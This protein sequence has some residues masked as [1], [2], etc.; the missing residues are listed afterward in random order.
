MFACRSACDSIVYTHRRTQAVRLEGRARV[1]RGSYGQG[2]GRHGPPWSGG[3]VERISPCGCPDGAPGQ[4]GTGPLVTRSCSS[5]WTTGWTGGSCVRSAHQSWVSCI[6]A[7]ASFPP[8]LGSCCPMYGP[9]SERH[10]RPQHPSAS[11]A[12]ASALP[13]A[14][15]RRALGETPPTA[16][17]SRAAGPHSPSCPWEAPSRLSASRSPWWQRGRSEK[18]EEAECPSSQ[19]EPNPEDVSKVSGF[20][21]PKHQ[22]D[23]L[24]PPKPNFQGENTLPWYSRKSYS[25]VRPLFHS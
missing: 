17:A 11:A 25:M 19:A 21:P 2:A 5:R 16:S 24:Y 15:A 7:H 12:P 20:W 13:C 6:P 18:E 9:N 10:L 8:T 4:D 22:C 1:G 14:P 3:G 23:L